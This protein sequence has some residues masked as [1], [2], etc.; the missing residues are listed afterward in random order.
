[1]RVQNPT[2]D[3]FRIGESAVVQIRGN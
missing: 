1:V 3:L 2:P